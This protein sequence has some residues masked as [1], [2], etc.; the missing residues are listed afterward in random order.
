M[1]GHDDHRTVAFPAGHHLIRAMGRRGELLDRRRASRLHPARLQRRLT[2][3]ASLSGP[4]PYQVMLTPFGAHTFEI[5]SSA[6]EG[7]R[8]PEERDGMAFARGLDHHRHH[9]HAPGC[10]G[11]DGGMGTWPVRSCSSPSPGL[12][13]ARSSSLGGGA[14]W[15]AWGTFA[16]AI[17]G[18]LAVVS[19]ASQLM[20]E[21]RSISIAGPAAEESAAAAA[22]VQVCLYALA[23]GLALG[24]VAGIVTVS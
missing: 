23:A 14:E 12:P 24:M 10:G 16:A 7:P 3:T 17:L 9:R 4:P 21:S 1:S 15:L 11:S 19:G 8:D 6:R 18:E 2:V 13:S 5:S 22:G 20:D